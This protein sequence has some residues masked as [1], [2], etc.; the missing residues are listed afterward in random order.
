MFGT[1][2]AKPAAQPAPSGA[3]ESLTIEQARTIVAPLYDALNQPAKKDVAALLA[4]AANPDYRSYH[5]NEESLTRDQLAEV[6]KGIGAA[7]PD[8]RWSIMDIQ[9]LGDQIVVRGRATGTP[10]WEFWGA[11]PTGKSFN[12]MAIDIFTVKDGKLASAYHVENWVGAL[13]QLSS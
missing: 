13:Q 10:K 6:F 7:V 12:T 2:F 4:K 1:S 3:A 11:K 8:L 9:I 5:T